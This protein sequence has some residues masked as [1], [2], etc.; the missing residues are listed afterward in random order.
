LLINNPVGYGDDV[1]PADKV[2][3]ADKVKPAT[4]TKPTDEAK[5][6][7]KVDSTMSFSLKKLI[8][9][10]KGIDVQF[11]TTLGTMNTQPL[12]EKP[13]QL[14]V[15]PEGLKS[16]IYAKIT[17]YSIDFF[18]VIKKDDKGKIDKLYVDLNR[19]G[20]LDETPAEAVYS[21]SKPNYIQAYFDLLKIKIKEK[22]Y[23]LFLRYYSTSYMNA[24]TKE[25]ANYSSVSY[26]LVNSFVADVKIGENVRK[27]VV[28]DKMADDR[29]NT[30]DRSGDV[31]FLDSNNDGKYSWEIES[32]ET[33]DGGELISNEKLYSFKIDIKLMM[34]YV[35]S[36]KLTYGK[37]NFNVKE[38]KNLVMKISKGTNYYAP[39]IK[40]EFK[41]GVGSAPE[42]KYLIK[43]VTF[44]KNGK[45][46][47]IRVNG[48]ESTDMIEITKDKP[49]EYALDLHLR[50]STSAYNYAEKIEGKNAY[51]MYGY[52]Y[53]ART[54]NVKG[55]EKVYY[56][57]VQLL[58]DNK[59]F[60]PPMFTVKDAEGKEIVKETAGKPFC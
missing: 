42:G 22:E 14:K 38:A 21:Y 13:E 20:K 45:P 49:C 41:D 10:P 27:L 30:F 31:I 3:P 50:F 39:Q 44:E 57:R 2:E 36:K 15:I 12:A 25:M 52:V 23:G 58:V 32:S 8:G 6:A 4:E 7:D 28:V 55:I 43:T 47:L 48:Y 26:G 35:Q 24:K 1:K 5:P 46:C 9:L 29:I 59:E 60:G 51:R 17:M 18:A 53:N 33:I 37:I 34:V 54:I 11:L 40:V 56:T 16:P 19:D